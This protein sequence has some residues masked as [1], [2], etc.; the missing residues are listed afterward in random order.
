MLALL[1]Q[2]YK[3]AVESG[4][5]ESSYIVGGTVRDLVLGNEIKDADIAFKGDALS[6]SRFFAD[7]IKA[8]FV[9]LDEKFGIARIALRGEYIDICT[10]YGDSIIDD[11]GNR[12]LTINAMAIP[13]SEFGSQDSLNSI[14]DPYG[15]LRDLEDNRVRMVSEK[16]LM[17]DPL[18]M[19][20]VFRFAAALGFSIDASTAAAVQKHAGLIRNSAP[21]RISVELRHILG[22]SSSLPTFRIMKNSG[23]LTA[24]FPGMSGYSDDTWNK[25]WSSLERIEDLLRSP[26]TCFPGKDSFLRQYFATAYRVECLKL[27]ILLDDGAMA[28][29]AAQRLKLSNKET[30]FIN[31]LSACNQTMLSVESAKR[32]TIIGLLKKLGDDIYAVLIFGIASGA[33]APY[34]NH[35]IQLAREIVEIYHDE[36]LPRLRRLP[37]ITGDDLI[38]KFG[39]S[40]SPFFKDILASIELLALEGR[41]T[42]RDEALRAAGE[43]IKNKGI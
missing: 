41:L 34:Q 39:L 17:S 16:N 10:L 11:L 22:C 12:D 1:D 37:F 32:S 42:T 23:L 4:H 7:A 24:L 33:K 28:E 19:L 30:E 29:Q 15:G 40:P 18:R 9:L 13:L 5:S 25:V 31:T 8:S 43:M 36:Y 20:R 3:Y 6:I 38:N 35:L 2:F 14:I 21:E 26:E 27:T